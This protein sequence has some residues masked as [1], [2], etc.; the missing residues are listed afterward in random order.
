MEAYWLGECEIVECVIVLDTSILFLI[1]DGLAFFDNI[2]EVDYGCRPI[3]IKPVLQEII[4]ISKRDCGKKGK[5]AKWILENIVP[6][7]KVEDFTFEGSVDDA[8]IAFA[9]KLRDK[10]FKV[11]IASADKKVREK[12]MKESIDVIVY[13]FS[14]KMFESL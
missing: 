3:L 6:I 13:R 2:Y 8:L 1:A 14:E 9:K 4:N 11:F 7:I 12:A 10:G 5:L